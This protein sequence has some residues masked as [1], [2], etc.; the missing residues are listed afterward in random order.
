MEKRKE[1]ILNLSM[2]LLLVDGEL[3]EKQRDYILNNDWYCA[4]IKDL[5]L[6]IRK[7]ND[8]LKG[9]SSELFSLTKNKFDNID[10]KNHHIYITFLTEIIIPKFKLFIESIKPEDKKTILKE[11]VRLCNSDGKISEEEYEV[12]NFISISLNVNL[13]DFFSKNNHREISQDILKEKDLKINFSFKDLEDVFDLNIKKTEDNLTNHFKKIIKNEV[14]LEDI[15]FELR[16]IKIVND[17]KTS[18]EILYDERSIFENKE[19]NYSG[20]SEKRQININEVDLFSFE[21]KDYE[22]S[23]SGGQSHFR[24]DKSNES[25][26]CNTCNGRKK[27]TCYTCSGSGSNKCNTCNGRGENICSSCSGSSKVVCFSCLSTGK[28]TKFSDGRSYTVSCSRCGGSGEV[29]CRS[30]STGYI[31][32][33]TCSGRGDVSCYSCSGKGEI[34]CSTCNGQGSFTKF[35]EVKSI[36]LSKNNNSFVDG[37]IDNNYYSKEYLND[38][39][40]YKSEF[41]KYNFSEV[42]D[43]KNHFKN[44]YHK[45]DF[46]K[47]Q[48]PKKIKFV[49][50]NCISLKFTLVINNKS[51]KGNLLFDGTIWYDKSFLSDL[52]YLMIDGFKIDNDFNNLISIKKSLINQEKDFSSVFDKIEQFKKFKKIVLSD[53]LVEIKLNKIRLISK[54]QINDYVKYLKSLISKKFFKS[55]TIILVIFHLL[56]L[57]IYP[58]WTSLILIL[59]II[60][61]TLTSILFYY[62]LNNEKID[63]RKIKLSWITTFVIISTFSTIGVFHSDNNYPDYPFDNNLLV[64]DP[65]GKIE[66]VKEKQRKIDS[67]LNKKI[68]NDLIKNKDNFIKNMDDQIK[69]IISFQ[70][71]NVFIELREIFQISYKNYQENF[72]FK[73]SKFDT[74]H[75]L[76]RLEFA[77]NYFSSYF[78]VINKNFTLTDYRTLL[79]NNIIDDNSIKIKDN[80]LS[81]KVVLMNPF[82]EETTNYFIDIGSD[83]E[84]EVSPYKISNSK[85][86]FYLNISESGFMQIKEKP[87]SKFTAKGG[88]IGMEVKFYGKDVI[89]ENQKNISFYIYENEINKYLN[90]LSS[91]LDNNFVTKIIDKNNN[92]NKVIS[93]NNLNVKVSD[94][95]KNKNLTNSKSKNIK[96]KGKE[97]YHESVN[98]SDKTIFLVETDKFIIRIDEIKPYQFRYF[99]WGGEK[100]ISSKPSLTL[101][102]GERIFEGNGGNNYFI[103]KNGNLKYIVGENKISVREMSDGSFETQP[104]YYLKVFQNE[105]LILEQDGDVF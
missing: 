92:I 88:G 28:K 104:K 23:K 51:Y 27:N 68:Y 18:L 80:N 83:F 103:F 97:N 44:L 69:K 93:K 6:V 81:Q 74:I 31:R 96:V 5:T 67:L 14:E 52:F 54:I 62:I 79:N 50:Y 34:Q 99:S 4:N 87:N 41:S 65:L 98:N 9:N 105:K 38:E 101:L 60:N 84:I 63:S 48:V 17:K 94:I 25:I 10:I 61:I 33:T 43:F 3:N 19:I 11:L 85:N 42:E 37:T 8:D 95:L 66:S 29:N 102:N 56:L 15:N 26:S 58:Q 20:V 16:D 53:E 78:D 32:C 40:D 49:V 75:S 76:S 30:C 13:N 100:N 7:F 90:F 86:K 21:R 1:L 2:P 77:Q 82:V 57:L 35:Y 36:L 89:K 70:N 73:L 22:F 71:P 55:Y 45:L 64:F 72:K 59:M 24:V 47:N 91:I 12:L 39:F 46:E